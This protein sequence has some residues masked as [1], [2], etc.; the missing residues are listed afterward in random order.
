[1]SARPIEITSRHGQLHVVTV[2][3]EDYGFLMLFKWRVLPSG[4]AAT[5]RET[6]LMHRVI[7][8]LQPGDPLQ[9]DHINR[10][11]LDNRREN[12]RVVTTA[13]N[14]Q[15]I[16]AHNPTGHRGVIALAGERFAARVSVG[17]RDTARVIHG[18]TFGTVEEAAAKARELRAEFMPFANEEVA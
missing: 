13:E 6:L 7:L 16:T 9:G 10:N 18:G 12:L 4:Y 3:E 1:M 2:S 5:G 8:N 15:N 11:R 17:G 14:R